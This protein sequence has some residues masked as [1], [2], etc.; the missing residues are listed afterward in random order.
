[1]FPYADCHLPWRKPISMQLVQ[2]LYVTGDRLWLTFTCRASWP[3][4]KQNGGT[5]HPR[6]W[7]NRSLIT[8]KRLPPRGS[9]RR[10]GDERHKTAQCLLV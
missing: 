9:R 6:M 5:K 2:A 8:A 3:E 10:V 7:A 1:M 4:L